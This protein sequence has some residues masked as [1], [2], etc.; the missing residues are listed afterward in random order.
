MK[1]KIYSLDKKYKEIIFAM[2]GL[3]PNFFM[4]LMGAY[5][6]DAINTAALGSTAPG[7]V[8]SGACLIVPAL[9]P[10]LWMIGKIFDGIIDIPFASITDNLS[11]KWGRRRPPILI[12]FLP[13]VISY[14]MCWLPIGGKGEDANTWLN[15]FWIFSWA[16]IFFATYT[17]N[18]ICFYGSLS[19]VCKDSNQRLRVSSYKSFFDTISYCIVYALVPVILDALYK[20][21]GMRIDNF[22]FMASPL[23]LTMIIPLFIIKEGKKYGYP[24]NDG[25]EKSEKI[26]IFKSI[27]LTFGNR[28]FIHWNVVNCLSFFGLQMFLVAMNALIIGGMGL[29][30]TEMTILNTCAFAPVPI[31]LYLFNKLKK[32]KGIRFAYQTCL[33]TFAIAIMSFFVGSTYVLGD[34][35]IAKILVGCLG[36]LSASWAIGS[37]FMMPYMIPAEISSVEEK[38][39]GKNHS[40]M[41]FAAQAVL[42]SISGAIASAL[43][44][45]NIKMLFI[46]KSTNQIV[47]AK[48]IEEAAAKMGANTDIVFNFGTILVPFIVAILCVVSFFYAFK[49][50]KNPQSS[51]KK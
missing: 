34:N 19:N 17:M 10:I 27:K 2:S 18:L 44:Y 12:C 48:S 47:Y 40:S 1:E 4:V 36:G 14:L 50:P 21:T 24:E 25:Q 37:F 3:G 15:T 31:C 13:M 7:Q 45:E 43:V 6:S 49:M 35:K 38:I 16:I 46:N 39:T 11:T 32:K 8:L 9:F 29:S 22:V 30:G 28:L 33:I 41:Y 26:N 42:S 23:M 5:F 51:L 20:N